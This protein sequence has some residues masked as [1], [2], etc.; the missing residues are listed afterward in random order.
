MRGRS[1]KSSL[2]R[3]ARRQV[4]AKPLPSCNT[5]LPERHAQVARCSPSPSRRHRTG[6]PAMQSPPQATS[7]NALAFLPSECRPTG[8][9]GRPAGTNLTANR[10]R[11]P[12]RPRAVGQRRRVTTDSGPGR[13][14]LEK[15]IKTSSPHGRPRS[16]GPGP[17]TNLSNRTAE[18]DAARALPHP[19]IITCLH[20][21]VSL[22]NSHLSGLPT[23]VAPYSAGPSK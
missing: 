17:R 15:S 19:N 14:P 2:R 10:S 8:S 3:F 18:A 5:A 22:L 20:G 21:A 9:P 4:K 12:C 16:S 13:K 1:Q 11:M 23:A 7:A 6:C